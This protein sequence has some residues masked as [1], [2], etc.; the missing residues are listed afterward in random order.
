MTVANC[1]LHLL[2]CLA[3]CGLLLAPASCA[4]VERQIDRA[5][6]GPNVPAD[7]AVHMRRESTAPP[8]RPPRERYR[9]G[10]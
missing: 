6:G 2:G 7:T 10:P 5:A 8:R 9:R 3:V 4:R 1:C